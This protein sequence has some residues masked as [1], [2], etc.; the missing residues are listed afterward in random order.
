MAGRSCRVP[1]RLE[2]LAARWADGARSPKTDESQ[3]ITTLFFN[4]LPLSKTFNDPLTV[5]AAICWRAGCTPGEWIHYVAANVRTITRGTLDLGFVDSQN[6]VDLDFQHHLALGSRN[7]VVWGL[8]A[9]AIDSNYGSG[10]DFTILPSHRLDRLV[11]VFVQ[12]ELKLADSLSLTVGSKMEHNDFTGFEFEPSAQLVWTPTEKQTVWASASRAIRE[13]SSLDD[14]FR[15]DAASVPLGSTFGIVRVLGNPYLRAEELRDF[16]T[17]YRLQASKRAS[18]EVT[19]F[20]GRYRNLESLAPQTPY[21]SSQDGVPYMV[22]PEVFV[23]GAGAATYGVEFSGNWKV[24]DRWRISP[25]YSYFHMNV[26]GDSSS[27]ATPPGAS[28]DHQFQIRSQLDLPY[29]LEWDSTLGYV[30]KLSLGNIPAYA[31]LD[32]RL[33]W[34]LGEFVELSL[35]GQNLLTAQ[36][37]E[38]SGTFYP[39]NYTLVER[40]AFGKVTWRF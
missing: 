25:G 36:H 38:F 5:T 6:T 4:A 27:V 19:G 13:P 32:T 30:S 24:T 12:D 39:L 35:V 26:N 18:L 34:R 16:E 23:N 7:D 22:L 37:A 1:V 8:G 2:P 14:G 9:R 3:T 29:H 15:E 10:Y 40:S 33:G 20:A 21:F 28:P 31:R 17:G 11:S